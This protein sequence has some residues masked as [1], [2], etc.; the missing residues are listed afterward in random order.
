MPGF[1][2]L[3]F[4]VLFGLVYC[5]NFD[6][7]LLI[8]DLG[9]GFTA[10]H[11][12]F[13]STASETIF[14]SKHYNILPKSV[15]QILRKY[16]VNEFHLSISRGIWDERWGSNFVSVSPSGAELWAWFGNQTSSVDQSWFELTHALSGLFCASLNQLSTNEHFASPLYSYKPLGVSESGK[17]DGEVRYSQLPGETLCS[18]NLT[19]WT[20]YLPCKSFSGLGSLLRPTSLFKS[21]YNSM[22]VGV[23]RICLDLKCDTVGLE[24]VATLTAVFD[25][26]LIFAKRTTPWSIK[27]ILGSEFRGSCSA[28]DSSR[29]FILKS[30]EDVDVNLNSA[31]NLHYPSNYVLAAYSTKDLS[32]SF[33]SSPFTVN[34]QKS[35]SYP[36][37]LISATK[38]VTGSGNVRGGVKAVLTNRADF[39]TKIIYFDLIPWYM[40]VFFSSLKIYSLNPK[41]QKS[42]LIKPHNLVIK[43]GL[44][45]KRMA[46]IELIITLPRHSQVTISYEF[47]KIL[48]RWNEFPPDANHGF[49]L[50]AATVSYMLNNEQLHHLNQTRHV[51][52][53]NLKLPNWAST[54]SQF[55]N[56]VSVGSRPGDGFVRLHTPVSLV[57][58]P[59]PDFSMP[60]NVLCL[61]CSI[62]A[63]VFGSVHKATT[64]VLNVTLKKPK[65]E[66][67]WVD[68]DKQIFHFED[69]SVHLHTQV[70]VSSKYG[71]YTWKCAEALSTY[72]VKHPEEV[73]GLRVLELGAGTG[74][75]G[76]VA[77]LLGARHVQ[78]TDNDMTCANKLHFN[79]QLNGISNY[80]FTILDWNYPLS[81]TGDEFDVIL[82]SDCLYDKKVYEPFI[83]TAALQLRIG[84]CKSLLLSFENRR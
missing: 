32:P 30:Y 81:Y 76:I 17:V 59:T 7:E 71:H 68:T 36:L 8:K 20:K 23:R 18:E 29:V 83:R 1:F 77:A 9:R 25:R 74:L 27:S 53:H 45:R 65:N 56:V 66:S 78:F 72:L 47:R 44:A 21:N 38:Y 40:Q 46:S 37:P 52:F 69:I 80:N 70:S 16:S 14:F 15:I 49:F 58:M 28:S 4:L 26:S 57:T 67:L 6:E 82:A 75:C 60:F 42:K 5:E 62:I 54:Y 3:T 43:P 11:F 39:D 55:F 10:F 51:A 19:P 48:Q 50:P 64:T 13:A 35:T 22:T 33:I 12:N 84:N 41:T 2:S 73:R 63:V 34:E 24:L 79:A 31:M 61:V